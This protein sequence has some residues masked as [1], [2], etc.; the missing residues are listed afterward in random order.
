[1]R[2]LL[3][4][5]LLVPLPALAYID[6]SAGGSLFMI[7]GP[8]TAMIISAWLFLKDQTKAGLSRVKQFLARKRRTR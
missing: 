3:L 1:M 5:L 8:I 7:L 6:P 2:I 4:G